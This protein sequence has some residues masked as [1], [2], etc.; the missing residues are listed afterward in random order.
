MW[1]AAAA[2]VAVTLA[3]PP[4]E[5]VLACRARIAG[6][7]SLARGEALTEAVR[8]LSDRLLDYGI[9]CEATA[10]AARAARRA[11]LSHA[12]FTTLEGRTDG[13]VVELTVVDADER[14]R[15]IRRLT[16]A[17]GAE[18][19]RP[20]SASLDGLVAEIPRPGARRVRR[21]AAVG[22]A[23]GGVALVGAG[24]VLAALARGEADRANAATTPGEYTGAR[25]SWERARGWSGAALGIGAAALAAGVIWRLDLQGED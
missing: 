20:I 22:V 3:I 16:I 25:Q 21:R 15:A 17:P 19:V 4:G 2:L 1:P 13:S 10:E 18:I 8:D 6:D 24:A 5:R 11:G 12:I 7:P 9:P 23:G 14:V